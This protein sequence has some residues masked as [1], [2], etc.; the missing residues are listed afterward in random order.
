[1]TECPHRQDIPALVLGALSGEERSALDAHLSACADCRRDLAELRE[2]ASALPLSVPQHRPP[3]ELKKRL[4]ATVSAEAE[5]LRAAGPAADRPRAP[6]RRR[7][8]RWPVGAGLVAAAALAA[9]SIVVVAGDEGPASGVRTVEASRSIGTSSARIEV[10][11]DRG[12]LVIEGA[13]PPPSG[14][15]YALWTVRPGQQ[16]RFAGAIRDVAGGRAEAAIDGNLD[17]VAQV[18]MTIERSP[19]GAAPTSE[20]VLAADL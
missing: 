10:S 5:L 13:P 17:G 3:P 9:G 20:P 14:S 11:G 7:R 8:S 4:M 6:A 18:L 12:R 16:P 19:S 15:E 1:M 2:D